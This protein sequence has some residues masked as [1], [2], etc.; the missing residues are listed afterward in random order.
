MYNPKRTVLVLASLSLSG[1]NN[2]EVQ[3]NF[4]SQ[5]SLEEEIAYVFFCNLFIKLLDSTVI[6]D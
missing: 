6:K 1:N 3:S 4:Y 2:N 5:K